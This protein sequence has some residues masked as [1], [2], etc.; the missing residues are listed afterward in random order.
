MLVSVVYSP[1]VN[2]CLFLKVHF[3]EEEE[4]PSLSLMN[5]TLNLE[6]EGSCVSGFRYT[7]SQKPAD[8]CCNRLSVTG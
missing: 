4:V 5:L 1:V 6:S 3:R 2:I 8:S 7:F